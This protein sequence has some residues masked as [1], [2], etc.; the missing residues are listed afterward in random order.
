R[1]EPGSPDTGTAPGQA[2]PDEEEE[3]LEEL[4]DVEELEEEEELP[5]AA[6]A[7]EDA[8]DL[9]GEDAALLEETS[10]HPAVFSENTYASLKAAQQAGPSA[11]KLSGTYN[12]EQLAKAGKI[13]FIDM[14]FSAVEATETKNLEKEASPARK[15]EEITTTVRSDWGIDDLFGDLGVDLGQ[16]V[17]EGEEAQVP[18]EEFR[19]EEKA[20]ILMAMDGFF[21][22]D[23]F[24]EDFRAD[25][26]GI[27]KSLMAISRAFPSSFFCALMSIEADELCLK[28]QIGL[29]DQ[30]AKDYKLPL[31]NQI[32]AG[33]Q[34]T[35]KAVVVQWPIRRIAEFKDLIPATDQTSGFFPLF[36]PVVWRT[37]KS[38]LLMCVASAPTADSLIAT[39][40]GIKTSWASFSF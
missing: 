18:E 7:G 9:D 35:G 28:Y 14:S 32:S 11:L 3:E 38:F 29:L 19:K 10:P 31:V 25:D 16:I 40:K 37:D 27:T 12:I 2:K 21:Q 20:K 8:E 39:L 33:I 1:E 4:E 5:A 6:A 13:S 26:R 34:D 17:D 23:R 30:K 36:I 24:L 15:D 22:Y